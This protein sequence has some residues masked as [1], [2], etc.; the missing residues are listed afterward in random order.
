MKISLSDHFNT[1]KLILFALPS[2]LM[3]IFISIY[4]VVDG[5]FV[6][7]FAKDTQFAALNF[8]YPVIMIFSSLGFMFGTGGSALIAKKLG[9]NKKEKANKIF[10][11]LF[12]VCIVLGIIFSILIIIFIRPIAIILGA[13]ENMLEYCVSYARIVISVLPFHI[14]QFYFQSLLI[15]AEKPHVNLVITLISGCTN[16]ALD[17]LFI[18]IFNWGIKGAALATAIAIVLGGLIPIFYFAKKNTS[19]LKLGRFNINFKDLFKV[20]INGSSEFVANISMSVVS[21]LYNYQLMKYLG[22]DGVSA[23]GTF[24]YVGMIF[25]AIFIGFSSSVAPIVSYNLGAKNIN[26][27]KGV[28]KRSILFIIISSIGM[29]LFSEVM[30]YPLSYLFMSYDKELLEL[31]TKAMLI[32]SIS[33]LFTGMCIF[34][35]AF[36]TALNNGLISAF[37]SFVRTLIIQVAAVLLLPL[38]FE[39]DGI[40]ISL[41]VAEA[42]A[43]IIGI[44]FLIIKRKQYQY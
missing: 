25:I 12:Y 38:I 8:I 22:Q 33:F 2:I 32:S 5:F 37:I 3:M 44:I 7:N 21:M 30:A 19:L 39:A 41:I 29:A 9:E 26:E 35:S 15:T 23:Y 16:M 43:S 40:W 18:V 11:M 27:L 34:S 28:F 4:G 1:K 14:L 13:S 36:F 17:A 31:T 42:F 10:T 24:M 20:C 6:S